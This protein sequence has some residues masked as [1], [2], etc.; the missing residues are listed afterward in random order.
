[1]N[2]MNRCL[3]CGTLHETWSQATLCCEPKRSNK[4]SDTDS[5][6][7]ICNRFT[8]RGFGCHGKFLSDDNGA[9]YAREKQRRSSKK[10]ALMDAVKS[11]RMITKL[12]RNEQKAR[13][14]TFIEMI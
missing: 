1:M 12:S 2:N 14:T 4:R 9:V 6:C 3:D 7:V 10:Q 13:R 5:R 11:D 8:P